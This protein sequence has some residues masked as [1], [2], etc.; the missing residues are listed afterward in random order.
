M[1]MPTVSLSEL[2]GALGWVSDD[3]WDSEAYVC[4]QTGK[5]Y[6]TS[7]EPG[8]LDEEE[9]IPDDIDDIGKYV[10]VPDQHDLDLGTR[11]VFD[12]AAEH[13]AEQYGD[14]RNIFRSKGAYGRFKA[15][16]ERQGALENWYAYS[17][18]RTLSALE[19]WCESERLAFER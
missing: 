17:D 13:L 6:W 18:E 2:Q 12:F 10:P 19:V 7:E 9:E 15:L 4:R 3:D 8:V 5:I 16:L 1:G 14:V 11:L